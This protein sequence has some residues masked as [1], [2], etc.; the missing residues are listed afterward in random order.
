MC[1]TRQF[2]PERDRYFVVSHPAIPPLPE[3][4]RAALRPL[5]EEAAIELWRVV[6][7]R[8][9]RP[10]TRFLPNSHWSHQFTVTGPDWMVNWNAWLSNEPDYSDPIRTFLTSTLSWGDDDPIYFV[11]SGQSIL[12]LPWEMFLAYWHYFLHTD[13]DALL[14]A[15][16]RSQS[17]CFGETGLLG[18]GTRPL[19]PPFDDREASNGCD[20]HP[21]PPCSTPTDSSPAH[22]D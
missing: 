12:R 1:T 20:C 11:L 13:Q 22:L 6:V 8:R 15:P 16:T 14:I 3:A 7:A 5:T 10:L 17:V 19:S 18:V 9:W 2:D 4:C 21:E